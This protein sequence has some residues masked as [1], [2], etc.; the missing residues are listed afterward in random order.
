MIKPRAIYEN[1]F[2]AS[3]ILPGVPTSINLDPEWSKAQIVS[4]LA[5]ER[6]T[7]T[8]EN[9]PEKVIRENIRGDIT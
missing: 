2:S 8:I 7:S 1:S 3:S 4:V 5:S 9:L 6:Y